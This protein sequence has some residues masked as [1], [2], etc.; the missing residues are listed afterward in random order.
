MM[1]I[2]D[3]QAALAKA[4]VDIKL[5]VERIAH[6]TAL[7]DELKR[8]GHDVT[9][10]VELLSVLKGTLEAMLAYRMTIV[11]QIERLAQKSCDEEKK[12]S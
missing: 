12:R 9:T 2:N 8:D 5:A 10:A 7:I 3:E 11:E 4:D 1:N 6:Q